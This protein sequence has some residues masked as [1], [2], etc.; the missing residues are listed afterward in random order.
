M[1]VPAVKRTS[2]ARV[3]KRGPDSRSTKHIGMTRGGR[4]TKNHA[5]VDGPGNPLHVQ[6]T[7]GQISD[8]TVAYEL[9]EHVD[10][11]GSVVMADNSFSEGFL[12]AAARLIR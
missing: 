9:L 1:T 4:N 5:T 8:I 6:L 12:K 3:Q 10:V 2:T 11:S 7:G